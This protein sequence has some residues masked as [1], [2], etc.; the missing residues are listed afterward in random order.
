[1]ATAVEVVVVL[2][3]ELLGPKQGLVDRMLIDIR[4]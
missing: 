4:F 1:M 2:V 3:V